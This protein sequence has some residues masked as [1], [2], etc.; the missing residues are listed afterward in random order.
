MEQYYRELNAMGKRLDDIKEKGIPYESVSDEI[1]TMVN[2]L[3]EMYREQRIQ[4]RYN[5]TPD[6][7]RIIELKVSNGI[8]QTIKDKLS[9]EVFKMVEINPLE[10]SNDLVQI[11]YYRKDNKGFETGDTIQ[12]K[13]YMLKDFAAFLQTKCI[14]SVLNNK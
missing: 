2:K 6:K 3:Q 10:D 1:T 13:H 9:S 14:A 4:E 11:N 5:I 7:F 12:L 8:L